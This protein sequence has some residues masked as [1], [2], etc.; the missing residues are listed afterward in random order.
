MNQVTR[1]EI[2]AS[3]HALPSESQPAAGVRVNGIQYDLA[4]ATQRGQW[5]QDNGDRVLFGALTSNR[6]NAAVATDHANSLLNV[7]TTSDKF[8]AANMSLLKRVAMGASPRI[9]PFKTSDGYEYYVAF[10]G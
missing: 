5:Q 3:L 7:D 1:D 2:I 4:T 9:R 10:A 8:T 6:V